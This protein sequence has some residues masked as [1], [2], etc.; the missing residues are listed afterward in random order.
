LSHAAKLD[1]ECSDEH[2]TEQDKGDDVSVFL[3]PIFIDVDTHWAILSAAY[4]K[5][6]SR[7]SFRSNGVTAMR[8]AQQH[9]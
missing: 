9:G 8:E 2:E 6:I 5:L 4:Q 7:S 3:K 1:R